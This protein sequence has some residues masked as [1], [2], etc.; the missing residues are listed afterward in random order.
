[1]A[2]DF[3]VR[4]GVDPE[5][6]SGHGNLPATSQ[7]CARMSSAPLAHSIANVLCQRP[8]AHRHFLARC[9]HTPRSTRSRIL[10]WGGVVVAM[11]VAVDPVD[12]ADAAVEVEPTG[13]LMVRSSDGIA[14]ASRHCKKDADLCCLRR[15]RCRLRRC[16]LHRC[17]L[18]L[19]RHRRRHHQVGIP[20]HS[21]T[22]GHSRWV[23]R[24]ADGQGHT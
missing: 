3:E 11:A 16:R 23:D 22:S 5:H 14:H 19:R 4:A 13:S 9:S 12:T 6:K 10:T 18:R 15:C 21:G 8:P 17:R 1:M 24:S 7:D 2:G 20:P